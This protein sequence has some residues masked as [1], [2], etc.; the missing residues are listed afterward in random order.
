MFKNQLLL[1]N[2]VGITRNLI[3]IYNQ[4]VEWIESIDTASHDFVVRL[5]LLGAFSSGKSSLINALVQKDLFATSIDPQTAVPAEL[6]YGEVTSYIGRFPDG[7][8]IPLHEQDIFNNN[9]QQLIPNGW[10]EV[11][12][13]IN[14]P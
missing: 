2:Y 5:P 4:P 13:G 8:T 11:L 9:L 10:V 7:K 6:S 12:Q 14:R 1:Q 3:K